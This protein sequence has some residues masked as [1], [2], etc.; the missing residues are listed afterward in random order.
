ML[1][2]PFV[3][4]VPTGQTLDQYQQ[5]L[6]DH[7]AVATLGPL[8]LAAAL[9]QAVNVGLA[10]PHPQ[11]GSLLAQ[12]Q[13][14]LPYFLRT[15]LREHPELAS[16]TADA[17]YQ[18]HAALGQELHQLLTGRTPQ[19]R[20]LGQ[21]YTRGAA[22]AN[23][24]AALSHALATA[25]PVL[26]LVRPLEEHLDQ[27][28]QHSTR[29]TLLDDTIA[30]Y[31]DPDDPTRQQE[32]A[33]LHHLSGVVAQERGHGTQVG[34]LEQLYEL[35]AGDEVGPATGSA[36]DRQHRRM[37]PGAGV[38]GHIRYPGHRSHGTHR[39]TRAPNRLPRP[40]DSV[41]EAA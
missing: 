24:S 33:R 40:S 9:A 41:V 5:L 13:P 31:G 17:H 32:L 10:A 16:A 20:A 35:D 21:A 18:L 14:V 8:N 30:A 22:Y 3:A 15:R 38:G 37:P 2:A 23:L 6:T 36:K 7:P 4:T 12:V 29:R 1:L 11:L 25:Q 19:E 28:Q 34:Q 26:P 39:D 27:T